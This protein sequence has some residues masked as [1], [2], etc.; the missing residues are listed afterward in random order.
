MHH[1]LQWITWLWEVTIGVNMD[2]GNSKSLTATEFSSVVTAITAAFGD[3]TRRDIYLFAHENSVGVTAA[4]TAKEFNLH[5][6]VARHHL[7][8]LAAGGYLDVGKKSDSKAGRPSKTYAC[9]DTEIYLDLPIRHQ[10]VLVTLLGKALS[11]LSSD[12]AE[13]LA[14]EVGF[15][16]GKTMAHSLGSEDSGYSFRQSLH[17]VAE[18][19]TAHGFAAHAKQFG[20]ELQ[21]I[22]EHCPFGDSAV[23]HPVICAVDRGMVKGMLGSLYGKTETTTSSSLAQGDEVCVTSVAL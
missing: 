6:N 11:L 15:E 10:D 23:K 13:A 2:T 22:S 3:K 21:I 18:A 4:E 8:K 14:E 5:P 19:L 17:A 9:T 1:T 20:D 7:D 12:Q 16:Y